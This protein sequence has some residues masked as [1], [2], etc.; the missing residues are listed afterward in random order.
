M[1]TVY[2]EEHVP[3]VQAAPAPLPPPVAARPGVSPG[4]A[5]VLGL[6]PGVGPSTTGNTPK[7]WCTWC[8]RHVD[9]HH[10]IRLGRWVEPLFG[11]L[12]ALWF[13]YMAF[14][15]YHTASKRL[16]GE[17]VDEFSSLFPARSATSGSTMTAVALIVLGVLFPHHEP[18]AGMGQDD[19]SLLAR[20]SDRRRRMDSG[21]PLEGT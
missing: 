10:G 17:P 6:I 14:E 16:R 2:C 15:A 3:A 8:V 5:F 1:G 18:A 21:K 13:F 12:I 9:Q 20:G 19:L 7:A 11:M 4:L